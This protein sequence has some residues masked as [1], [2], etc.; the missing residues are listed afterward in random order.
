MP[1]E[2]WNLEA[3][4]SQSAIDQMNHN[5]PGRRPSDMRS[6][7]NRNRFCDVCGCQLEQL[8]EGSF[9]CLACSPIREML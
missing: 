3:A 6:P 7:P 4:E 1:Y 5:D 2:D 9:V 8:P